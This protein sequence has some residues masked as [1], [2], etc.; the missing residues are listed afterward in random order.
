MSAKRYLLSGVG[1][2]LVLV[3]AGGLAFASNSSPAQEPQGSPFFDATLQQAVNELDGKVQPSAERRTAQAEPT[4]H[5]TTDP[6]LWPECQFGYTRDLVQW[7]SCHYTSDPTSPACGTPW[8][9]KDYTWDATLWPECGPNITQDPIAPW[10]NP[11]WTADPQMGTQCDPMY[12][13][14][15]ERWPWCNPRYTW[16]PAQWPACPTE[17]PY[18]TDD[19]VGLWPE[20]SQNEY[21][22]DPYLWAA[23]HYTSDPIVFSNCEGPYP[24]QDYTSNPYLWPECPGPGYTIDL[25]H[26]PWCDPGYTHDP[27]NPY[28]EVPY[29]YWPSQWPWCADPLYTTAPVWWPECHYTSDPAQPAC[30]QSYPT[31]DL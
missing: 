18:Y 17:P 26:W 31:K 29:T 3:V 1:A 25:M 10:C 11:L 5:Y 8:P 13:K 19:V 28:C 2:L 6:T 21:T 9:T 27:Q 23:C 12:T 14:D 16:D 22:S 24:T 15:P 4:Q 20:C 30:Q 7:P